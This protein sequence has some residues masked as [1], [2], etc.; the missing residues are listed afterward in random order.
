MR[1]PD[2][3]ITIMYLC[4]HLQQPID[5]FDGKRSYPEFHEYDIQLVASR[6]IEKVLQSHI[7]KVVSVTGKLPAPTGGY[8]S[9]PFE[10]TM[11]VTN[12]NAVPQRG[13]R[14]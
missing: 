14:K 12:V 5:V 11:L 8:G 3:K 9:A 4:L 10:L 13:T 6:E 1:F 7:G 2:D